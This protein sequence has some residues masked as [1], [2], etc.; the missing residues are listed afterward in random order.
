MTSRTFVVGSLPSATARTAI[1]RS[2]ITPTRRSFSPTGSEP[3][4]IS[5]ITRAASR[6][7]S[8]GFATR[9]SRVIASLTFIDCS[10]SRVRFASWRW[11]FMQ[12]ACH[13]LCPTT[14]AAKGPQRGNSCNRLTTITPSGAGLCRHAAFAMLDG[15]FGDL[16]YRNFPGRFVC[17]QAVV[18]RFDAD[19]EHRSRGFAR[20]RVLDGCENQSFLDCI[21]TIADG[22]LKG[23]AVRLRVQRRLARQAKLRDPWT[24][25]HDVR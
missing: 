15:D 12:R 1:S 5:A 7:V 23:A 2:V 11:R 14:N 21:D 4:L 20:L 9:T 16:R 22:D 6:I 8:L 18:Q 17:A 3:A 24:I 25:A 19:A 13:T 10:F